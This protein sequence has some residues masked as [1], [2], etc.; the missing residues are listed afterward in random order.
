MPNTNLGRTHKVAPA[1]VTTATPTPV[2]DDEQFMSD[3][4]YSALTKIKYALAE[5][6]WLAAQLPCDRAEATNA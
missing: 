3:R 5:V 1:R 6:D 4:R 2:S